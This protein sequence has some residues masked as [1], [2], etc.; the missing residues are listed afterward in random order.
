ME[1]HVLSE[2]MLT[3]DYITTDY[4]T[5]VVCFYN[6]HRISSHNTVTHVC[7]KNWNVFNENI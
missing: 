4:I 1:I 6:I 2:A 5:L 7:N 3:T